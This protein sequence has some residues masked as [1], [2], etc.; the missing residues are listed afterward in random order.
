MYTIID[1][2]RM[3]TLEAA[4]S[5]P[6]SMIVIRLDSMGSDTGTVIGIGDDD[7]DIMEFLD[8]LEDDTECLITE[9]RNLRCCLGGIV[10]GA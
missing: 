5:Y 6:D 3:T 8:I 7:N 2:E 9:G 1:N 10:V 4:E